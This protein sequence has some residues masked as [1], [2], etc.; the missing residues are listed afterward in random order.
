MVFVVRCACD[1]ALKTTCVWPDSFDGSFRGSNPV[2]FPG[3]WCPGRRLF[4]LRIAGAKEPKIS[5]PIGGCR[6]QQ[7]N[8]LAVRSS[9]EEHTKSACAVATSLSRVLGVEVEAILVRG[10]GAAVSRDFW[11]KRKSKM[12]ASQMVLQDHRYVPV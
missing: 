12:V 4:A 9:A 10:S 2:N 7:Q 3:R 8:A 11:M 1:Y 6:R 5:R